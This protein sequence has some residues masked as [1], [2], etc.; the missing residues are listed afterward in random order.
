MLFCWLIDFTFGDLK[1]SRNCQNGEHNIVSSANPGEDALPG[2]V[3]ELRLVVP[4]LGVVGVV[5]ER[6]GLLLALLT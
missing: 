3:V 5:V 6:L 4:L 2:D 1:L